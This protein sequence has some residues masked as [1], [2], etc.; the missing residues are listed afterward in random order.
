MVNS[1]SGGGGG[2]GGVGVGN[3]GGGIVSS[4]SGGSSSANLVVG[5][6]SDVQKRALYKRVNDLIRQQKPTLLNKNVQ[7][8]VK[9]EQEILVDQRIPKMSLGSRKLIG[10]QL[11]PYRKLYRVSND[12]VFDYYAEEEEDEADEVPVYDEYEE[13]DDEEVEQIYDYVDS[14]KKSSDSNNSNSNENTVNSVW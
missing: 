8:R 3:G 1:S 2:G 4:G 10:Y 7:N 6:V 13:D 5:Q 14:A 12:R 11:L 9:K